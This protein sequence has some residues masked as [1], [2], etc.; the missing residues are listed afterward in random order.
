ML[1]F[2]NAVYHML[3]YVSILYNRYAYIVTDILRSS[4]VTC[5]YPRCTVA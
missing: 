2:S 4:K 1:V 3:D 5:R